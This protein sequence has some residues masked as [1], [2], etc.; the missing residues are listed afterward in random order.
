MFEAA[1]V[2]KV[3]VP[4]HRTVA[5]SVCCYTGTFDGPRPSLGELLVTSP[6]G[7]VAFIGSN[8]IS[9]PYANAVMAELV[10]EAFT[11][12]PRATVGQALLAVQ[13]DLAAHRVTALRPMLDLAAATQLGM[14]NLPKQR[15]DQ[16]TL[17]NLLG[18]PALPLSV[19]H[20]GVRIDVSGE[21]GPGRQVTFEAESPAAK[22]QAEWRLSV[23]RNYM[24]GPEPQADKEKPE[25]PSEEL[26][27]RRHKWANNKTLLQ[28]EAKVA[29][30]KTT[31]T[32]Q[33]PET[34]PGDVAAVSVFIV[35]TDR[36]VAGHRT[37]L[38]TPTET[39]TDETAPSNSRRR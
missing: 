37:I 24:T 28:H 9:Q 23:R 27:A 21:V 13:T 18:D 25:G 10:V 3:D 34:V 29:D 17:Y 2:A 26:M 30:G 5:L 11:R 14:E 39:S 22:G 33:L 19:V 7:P 31:W 35:G 20:P 15:I 32:V 16:L 4:H 1:H 8:G 38:L 12:Q 6:K 36:T